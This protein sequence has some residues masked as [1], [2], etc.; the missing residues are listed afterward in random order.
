MMRLNAATSLRAP[1]RISS[2]RARPTRRLC[3]DATRAIVSRDALP[4]LRIRTAQ[5]RRA[6]PAANGG[7]ALALLRHLRHE[8]AAEPAADVVELLAPERK[9]IVERRQ[10]AAE[11]QVFAPPLL[12]PAAKRKLM[13]A[14]KLAHRRGKLG[15]DRHRHL[16]RAGRRRGAE[17]GGMV[18]E[19][20][21]GLVPDRGDDR[22][23]ACRD[24][25]H[26][27]LFVEGPEILD[28]AAAARDDQKIGTRKRAAAGDRVEAADRRR[29]LLR[30]AFPLHAHRPDEHMARETGRAG[31]AGCRGSPRR[32][33]R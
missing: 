32:S 29:D 10:R 24:G 22:D 20:R 2:R 16:R 33:A 23:R 9:E 1:V 30:R 21:V 18:D 7:V 27:H 6:V 12:H 15:A 4:P 5:D 28:R 17:I 31:D 8:R 19:R 26:R 11:R 25:A 3:A 14:R 13:A